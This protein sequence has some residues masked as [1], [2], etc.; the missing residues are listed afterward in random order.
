MVPVTVTATVTSLPHP[1]LAPRPLRTPVSLGSSSWAAAH[2]SSSA[3][4]APSSDSWPTPPLCAHAEVSP[5]LPAFGGQLSCRTPSVPVGFLRPPSCKGILSPPAQCSR[6]HWTGYRLPESIWSWLPCA[7][8]SSDLWVLYRVLSQH[9]APPNRLINSRSVPGSKVQGQLN[10][11][12]LAPRHSG[13]GGQAGD[14]DSSVGRF[15]WDRRV[16]LQAHHG[17]SCHVGRCRALVMGRGRR[18]PGV[19]DSPPLDFCP[20]LAIRR[21]YEARPVLRG[22]RIKCPF[23]NRETSRI[24]GHFCKTNHHLGLTRIISSSR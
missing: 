4:T 24:F 18:G 9:V 8:P 22:R 10:C 13:G 20:V 1:A 11:G 15:G 16:H 12:V 3:S 5:D 7:P 6:S 14:R 23:L 19:P 2:P 21:E 17:G